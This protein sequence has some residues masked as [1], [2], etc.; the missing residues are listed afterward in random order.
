[1]FWYAHQREAKAFGSETTIYYL[2]I[3]NRGGDLSVK[4]HTS[5]K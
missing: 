3:T 4:V 5:P 1:M 2:K